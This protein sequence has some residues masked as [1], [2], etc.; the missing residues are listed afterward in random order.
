MEKLDIEVLRTTESTAI[1]G[2]ALRPEVGRRRKT[3]ALRGFDQPLCL[4]HV[5]NID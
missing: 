4:I 2:D 5:R 3:K 1:N